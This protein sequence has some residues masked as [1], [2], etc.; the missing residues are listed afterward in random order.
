[1]DEAKRLCPAALDL[2]VNTDN[3][4]AL[5]FYEKN[6]FLRGESGT[7]PASGLKT[8]CL[9]WRPADMA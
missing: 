3:P 6:G 2:E 8:L 9:H 5:R 4:R 1:L 7:N